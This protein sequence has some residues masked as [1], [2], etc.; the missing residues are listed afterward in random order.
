MQIYICIYAKPNVYCTN[1][2]VVFVV[3]CIF[4]LQTCQCLSSR[5]KIEPDFGKFSNQAKPSQAKPSYTKAQ[6]H[7]KKNFEP[8][9]GK[10]SKNRDKPSQ[11]APSQVQ[12]IEPH[13]KKTAPKNHSQANPDRTK[14][15]R[16]K[17]EPHV[18]KQETLPPGWMRSM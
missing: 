10:P 2:I 12:T 15:S 13:I 6:P 16:T 18:R 3:C 8:N 11:T 4:V 17:A 1:D 9:L 14:P 7:R 5:P